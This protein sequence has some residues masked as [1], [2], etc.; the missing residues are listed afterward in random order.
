MNPENPN[1][2]PPEPDRPGLPQPEPA[3]NDPPPASTK[4]QNAN[5]PFGMSKFSIRRGSIQVQILLLSSLATAAAL[6]VKTALAS[7][8]ANLTLA[9]TALALIFI[10]TLIIARIS[11][12]TVQAETWIR[13]MGMG[14]LEYQVAP[15]G[16]D[17]I[18]K[19]MEALESLRQAS[20]RATRTQ[21]VERLSS[22]VQAKNEQLESLLDELQ[23]T[24]DQVVSRQKLA[25]LG[26]LTAGVAHEIRNPLNL[27]QNFAHITDE[28]LTELKDALAQLTGPPDQ[29]QTDL[30]GELLTH[31][32][33]NMTKLQHHGGRANRMV[34]DMLAMGRTT[35]GE[36]QSVDINQLVQDHTMLAY[37]SARS[38]D[39]EFNVRILTEYD[40]HAGRINVVA[41]DIGRVILNLVANACYATNERTKTDPDPTYQ[42]T[43][44]ITTSKN[45]EHLEISVR[46]NG[47]GIP[48]DTI[49]KV[50]NPFFT[51]KPTNKGTGLGLSMSNDIIREHSGTIVPE[52]E[53]MQYTKFTVRIP[54]SSAAQMA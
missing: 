54:V 26:E 7:D 15:T 28:M 50:F 9:A 36:F 44:W 18:T 20:I 25:E 16:N 46:D 21:Q 43:L 30:I 33:E 27:I 19:T 17:E 37:H 41:E 42:P 1:R 32:S 6:T 12:K 45:G 23:R 38:Q 52:S 5:D 2:T 8:A 53:P 3:R 24:Q 48:E 39:Y 29:Q 4:W 47:Q 22:K 34:Q 40:Q 11:I 14:D 35:K 49:R 51:T 10:T 13:K 31:M